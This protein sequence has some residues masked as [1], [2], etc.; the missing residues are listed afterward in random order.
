MTRGEWRRGL[1]LGIA[2]CAAVAFI[3][4]D[5][6]LAMLLT[7]VILP[8][9]MHWWA[10]TMQDAKRAEFERQL[11]EA[12]QGLTGALEAGHAFENA[13]S[14][15]CREQEREGRARTMVG[16][17]FKLMEQELAINIPVE[18]VW[19][20]FAKRCGQQ[21]VQEIAM[22]IDAGKRSGGNLIHVMRRC[23]LQ[24]AEK[25]DV[26]RE[27]EAS[28]SSRKMELYLMLM[29]PAAVLLYMRLVFSD[30]MAMLYGNAAG[31]A[32][33]TVCLAVYAAA[34]WLG[35]RIIRACS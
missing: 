32:V 7:A 3:F 2:L 33:M 11:A 23:M 9:F 28:L 26:R 21:D 13:I 16:R 15:I 12:L 17:E 4:Y 25:I 6:L 8:L 22:V 19:E 34:A 20:H 29:M 27:I 30:M 14:E 18:T 35:N 5:S 1:L 10:V 31:I 24:I